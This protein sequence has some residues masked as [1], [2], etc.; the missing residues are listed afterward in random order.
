MFK[1]QVKKNGIK[2][3]I[4]ELLTLE[5]WW[6]QRFQPSKWWGSMKKW[7]LIK[8]VKTPELF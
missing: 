4:L 7:S 6:V 2:K 3:V 1:W 5:E 8:K